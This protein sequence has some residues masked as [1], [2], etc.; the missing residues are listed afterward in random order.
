[1][2][3]SQDAKS[4]PRLLVG[5]DLDGTMLTRADRPLLSER[6][7]RA[8]DRASR[9]GIAVVLC[10]GRMLCSARPFYDAL[11]LE[12]PLI[13]HNGAVITHPPTRTRIA[14][15]TIP[16]RDAALAIRFARDAGLAINYYADDQLY[17]EQPSWLLDRYRAKYNI[18]ANIVDD[19]TAVQCDP[20]K[21]LILLPEGDRETLFARAS[22]ALSGRLTVTASEPEFV[23]IVRKD[24]NKG[25]AFEEVRKQLAVPRKNTIAIGDGLNDLPLLEAAALPVA[26]EDCHEKLRDCAQRIIPSPHDEGV[27]TFLEE[28]TSSVSD[29]P[30]P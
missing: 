18:S 22:A 5:T 3:T 30:P 19:L 16:A 28:L 24:V 27:A 13:T 10:T 26:V 6:T 14:E 20:T 25:A 9:S 23:E 4:R 17:A 1:M 7:V 29:Q 2:I 11:K 12:T 21:L 8:V 15:H